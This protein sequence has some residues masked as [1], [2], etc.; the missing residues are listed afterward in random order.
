MIWGILFCYLLIGGVV[1]AFVE[2]G[3]RDEGAEFGI[4]DWAVVIILFPWYLF[5]FVKLWFDDDEK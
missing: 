4:E 2:A 5:R 1:A 3:A